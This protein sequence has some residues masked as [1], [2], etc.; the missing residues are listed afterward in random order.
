M[1]H[2]VSES[3][4]EL[5]RQGCVYRVGAA[6]HMRVSGHR[7]SHIQNLKLKIFENCILLNDK[8]NKQDVRADQHVSCVANDNYLI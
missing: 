1:G 4:R 2:I 3:V 6:N 7:Y 5:V 8:K